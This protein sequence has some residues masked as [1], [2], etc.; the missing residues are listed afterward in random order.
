MVF[1]NTVFMRR[2][3]FREQ[4]VEKTVKFA[5]ANETDIAYLN[6]RI[7]TT[8]IW[9]PQSMSMSSMFDCNFF[10]VNVVVHQE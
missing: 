7:K 3:I 2:M 10:T 6:G 5:L 4:N 1:R 8:R 9:Y